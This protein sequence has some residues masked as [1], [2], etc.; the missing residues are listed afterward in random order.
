[1]PTIHAHFLPQLAAPDDVAGHTVVVLDILCHN[2]DYLRPGRGR[3]AR[4]PMRRDRR[5]TTAAA[6]KIAAG[7]G[8]MRPL[9]AGERHG[10]PDR[11]FRSRQLA[12]RV[13]ARCTGGRTLVFTTTNGTLRDAA[14]PASRARLLGAF[15]NLQ[16]LVAEFARGRR[17]APALRRDRRG[18]HV[19]GC[20]GRRRDHARI[21]AARRSD[22]GRRLVER[23]AERSGADCTRRL[24]SGAAAGRATA[25][26]RRHMAR[27]ALGESQGG[28]NLQRIGRAI[29]RIARRQ[30]V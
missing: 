3:E 8:Q 7:T 29:F 6:E 9:L 12:Q 21:D 4:D 30:S 22:L 18:N 15:V 10:L 16:A 11:R 14:L 28:R 1:M 20:A 24:A 19:R 17:I 26:Q 13:H 5:S 27:P 2:H 25:E 23:H